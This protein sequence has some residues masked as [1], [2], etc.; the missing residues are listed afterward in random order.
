MK[1]P[2]WYD[3][4]KTPGAGTYRPPSDFGYVTLSPRNFDVAKKLYAEKAKGHRVGF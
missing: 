4:F 3:R 2:E 1:R